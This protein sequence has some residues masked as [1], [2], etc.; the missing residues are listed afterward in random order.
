MLQYGKPFSRVIQQYTN[1][2]ASWDS[3][4]LI[5]LYF[6][7][8]LYNFTKLRVLFPTVLINFPNSKVCLIGKWSINETQSGYVC[9]RP[10]AVSDHGGN[11]T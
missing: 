7:T 11:R 10:L 3:I 9:S 6:A 5:L 1:S 2:Q 4:L 8:K